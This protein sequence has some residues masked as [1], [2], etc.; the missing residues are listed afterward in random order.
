M[1]MTNY[2][3]SMTNDQAAPPSG[4]ACAV[5]EASFERTLSLTPRFS[6][7]SVRTAGTGT[8]LAV[9]RNRATTLDPART[10]TVKT[11]SGSMWPASTPLKRGV[12]ESG[13][14]NDQFPMTNDESAKLG[15]RVHHNGHCALDI[16]WSLRIGHW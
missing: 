4:R 14:A 13:K 11:G 15:R 9:S 6:G 10:K 12:N 1:E 3:L 7:V 2:Q 5:A 16:H 8:A